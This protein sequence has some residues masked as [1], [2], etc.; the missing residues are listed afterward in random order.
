L[1]RERE[2]E[3]ER[4]RERESERE[5]EKEFYWVFRKIKILTLISHAD[6]RLCASMT[7]VRISL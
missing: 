6:M 7:L 3:K 2:R 4:E 5:R 1:E